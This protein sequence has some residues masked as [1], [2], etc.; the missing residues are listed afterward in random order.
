MAEIATTSRSRSTRELTRPSLSFFVSKVSKLDG[1]DFLCD[2][3]DIEAGTLAGT[4][5]IRN[6]TPELDSLVTFFE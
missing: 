2:R 1:I 6:L 3:V 4:L 5:E